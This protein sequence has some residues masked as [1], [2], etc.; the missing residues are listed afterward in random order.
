MILFCYDGSSDARAAI[1][2]AGKLLGGQAATVLTVWEPLIDVMARSGAGFGAGVIELDTDRIDAASE[3]TARERAE[4]GTERARRAGLDPEP[5]TRA[6]AGTI[7]ET[8]LDEAAALNADAVMLGTRGLT[9]VKSLLL[10]SVSHAVL[11]D[12][13]RPVFIVPSPQVASQRAARRRSP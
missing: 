4:E 8:I 1:D 10:G 5:R 13:D 9:G 6:R 11:Q 7:A 2:H 3:K 12:A